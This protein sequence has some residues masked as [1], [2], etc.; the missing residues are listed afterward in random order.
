MQNVQ[1]MQVE[2]AGGFEIKLDNDNIGD[3]EVVYEAEREKKTP[4]VEKVNSNKKFETSLKIILLV[5]GIIV[6]L[7]LI[8]L[9]LS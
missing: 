4:A 2:A 3:E 1:A 6:I 5:F 9:L 7:Y 8:L